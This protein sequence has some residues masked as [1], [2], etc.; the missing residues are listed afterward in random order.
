MTEDLRA[1]F[2][3]AGL[4]PPTRLT[5]AL[6]DDCNLSC[7][8]CWVEARPQRVPHSVPTG[9]AQELIA[10]FA[11]LGGEGLCL[12]GGE[13][14][15]HP[16]WPLLVRAATATGLR[17][18]VLQTNALLL[19]DRQLKELLAADPP[20]LSLEISL[21]G[22]SAASHDR[23][24]G[25]GGFV[26]TLAALR[27]LAAAGLAGAVTLCFTEMAHN[28][29]EFPALLELAAELG[30]AGVRGGTLIPGGRAAAEGRLL[31]PAPDQY[32]ALVRRFDAEP[33]FRRRYA[34]LGMLAA[35]EWWQ[36][37]SSPRPCCDLAEAPYLNP[38]GQLYPCSLCHCDSFAVADVYRRG[39]AASL[40]AALPRWLELKRLAARR[41]AEVPACAGCPE[42]DACAGGC[43]G[44][45]WGSCGDLLACDDRCATRQLLGRTRRESRD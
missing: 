25:R 10:E 39:L 23:V 40:E 35:L 44:R 9:A 43:V 26:A 33:Q 28:L 12:S 6:T 27:R 1:A 21:D 37:G 38:A 16:D 14:L 5:L 15:L 36:A 41:A 34:E 22:A 7:G 17:Q 32:L 18:L 42:R 24:R 2:A 3:A 45:A 30:V 29:A 31:P 11:A 19:G 4:K 13:P 8:H 20:G